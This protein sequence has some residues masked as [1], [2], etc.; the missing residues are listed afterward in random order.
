[1]PLCNYCFFF[2]ENKS[3]GAQQFALI[4]CQYVADIACGTPL[5]KET[6]KAEKQI[7]IGLGLRVRG[8]FWRA[9]GENQKMVSVNSFLLSK[10]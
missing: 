6:R 7:L 3:F 2:Q 1:V 4:L 9:E 8:T 10:E 5:T